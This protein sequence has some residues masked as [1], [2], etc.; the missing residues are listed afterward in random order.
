MN[1][2]KVGDNVKFKAGDYAPPQNQSQKNEYTADYHNLSIESVYNVEEAGGVLGGDV[3]TIKG[4]NFYADR[5]VLAETTPEQTATQN[6]DAAMKAAW[7]EPRSHTVKIL[8]QTFDYRQAYEKSTEVIGSLI[9][10]ISNRPSYDVTLHSANVSKMVKDCDNCNFT[11][12]HGTDEPCKDCRNNHLFNWQPQEE[13]DC[14]TCEYEHLP[15]DDCKECITD[16]LDNGEK[17]STGY[18]AKTERNCKDCFFSNFPAVMTAVNSPC[19]TCKPGV[20]PHWWAKVA[21][22]PSK[23]PPTA[24]EERVCNQHC[25]YSISGVCS[26]PQKGNVF[27]DS[28]IL[29][30]GVCGSFEKQE[31]KEPV[32]AKVESRPLK[33]CRLCRHN[34][35]V[36][37][38]NPCRPCGI[39]HEEGYGHTQFQPKEDQKVEPEVSEARRQYDCMIVDRRCGVCTDI[40]TPHNEYPC[41]GCAGTT[42]KHNFTPKTFEE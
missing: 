14:D 10:I 39:D 32:K 34:E 2:F 7:A 21:N 29:P 12:L 42:P 40:D 9:N 22:S 24:Q 30:E 18:K 31:P 11:N 25:K 41:E 1:E 28:R 3:I 6:F 5:F 37:Q 17:G 23:T 20:R 38:E 13:R 4:K 15:Y 26:K 27:Y 16:W 8:P 35:E 33:Q 36:S 19:L